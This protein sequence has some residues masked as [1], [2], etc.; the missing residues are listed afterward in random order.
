[1]ALV[2]AFTLACAFVAAPSA[3]AQDGNDLNASELAPIVERLVGELETRTGSEF[4]R[5]VARLEG[6][7]QKVRP[8]LQQQLIRAEDRGRL[9]CSRALL[10]LD[11]NLPEDD[12][13]DLA[14]EEAYNDAIGAL[15]RLAKTAAADTAVAAIEL[16]GNYGE[17]EDIAPFFKSLYEQSSGKNE[18][19][20]IIPLARLL[21]ELERDNEARQRLIDYLGSSNPEVR[22]DAALALASI[23]YYE[24]DVRRV[25]R[26][27]KNEPSA[28]GRI[29]AGLDRIVRLNRQFDRGLESGTQLTE[30]ADPVKLVA[31][32]E[33]R[34]RELEDTVERMRKGAAKAAGG[35]LPEDYELIEEVIRLIQEQYVDVSKVERSE[36]LLDALRGMV[37][38]LDPFSSFL[39]TES[40]KNFQQKIAGTYSGIGARVNKLPELPLEIVKPIYGGPAYEQGLL[41]HDKVIKIDDTPTAP[42]ELQEVVDLLKGPT[43]SEVKLTVLRRGW[44]DTKDFMVRRRDVEVSSVYADLLPGKIGYLQLLQF[45]DRSIDEFVA[46]L[47]ALEKDGLKG[48]IL[49]LRDNGGGRLSAAIQLVDQFVSND[50][51][52]PIVTQK[53]RG[54]KRGIADE[55]AT[56]PNAFSRPNYP[57]VVMINERSASASEIVAGALQDFGRAVVVG[58]RSFGKGSVQTLLQLSEAK[59][60]IGGE[61][62]LRLTI[63][64]YFLPL[65]RCI[66]TLRDARGVV[67]E[68]GGVEPDVSLEPTRIAVWRIEERERFRNLEV[69]LTYVA[70][71][72]EELKPTFAIGDG[73]KTETYPKFEALYDALDTA[74]PREDLRRVL[75]FHIRRRL[76]DARGREFACDYHEDRELQSAIRALLAKLGQLPDEIPEYQKFAPAPPEEGAPAN[77]STEPESPDEEPGQDAPAKESS[78]EN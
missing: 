36:L 30:G 62:V 44:S 73:G 19:K 53:G 26:R 63:Q 31:I 43:D 54:Q 28:K 40:S 56:Y 38:G 20:K 74:A 47:D 12:L 15:Q 75:R 3:T 59:Q 32:K 42:L 27:L 55:K 29:A 34:I 45:G 10:G 25:L 22:D 21:W 64:Y 67:T 69:V 66:H 13:D 5:G 23:G 48:L 11:E 7:G 6:L 39:D 60:A 17:P 78:D 58:R 72:F 33:R 37:S 57:L 65:G 18:V 24:G 70:K 49:D 71:H 52:L 46:A 16:L 8:I 35:S 61:A 2:L 76:E 4:W 68:Q 1:M 9:A 51:G 50:S 77:A 14:A 41:S